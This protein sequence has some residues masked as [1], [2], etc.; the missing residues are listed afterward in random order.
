M[1][2]LIAGPK[3]SLRALVITNI[4][5]AAIASAVMSAAVITQEP[6]AHKPNPE[7]RAS[8]I[9]NARS[10]T[11]GKRVTQPT[12][13]TPELP[14]PPDNVRNRSD[15]SPAVSSASVTDEP[16]Q[17]FSE[18]TLFLFASALALFVALLGWSDQIRGIN[19][20]TKE[21]EERFLSETGIAKRDFLC[22]V[23]PKVQ[24]EQ[25]AALAKLMKSGNIQSH[26]NVD[27]LSAFK[28]WNKE[29]SRLE[30]LSSIKYYLAIALTVA[31]FLAGVISLFTRP[32][33]KASLHYFAIRAELLVLTMPLALVAALLC[34]IICES[35]RENALR[36]FLE[37]IDDRV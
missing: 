16:K 13:S 15:C 35:R 10:R 5:C 34:I 26:V 37:S 3:G 31:F 11:D 25:L 8:K 4:L 7:P 1:I 24:G 12:T 36:V 19:K 30:K 22:V 27:L 20:D 28:S 29:W 18:L 6:P 21:L 33:D 14:A 32:G 2:D 23:K 17:S 9:V